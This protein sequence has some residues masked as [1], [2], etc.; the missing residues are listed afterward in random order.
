MKLWL[1][2]ASVADVSVRVVV[3]TDGSILIDL[4]SIKLTSLVVLGTL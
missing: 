4:L 2:L 1:G 3:R